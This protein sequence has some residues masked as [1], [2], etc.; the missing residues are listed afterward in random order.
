MDAGDPS[1]VVLAAGLG[2]RFGGGKSL[3][4]I[5]PGGIAI[6]DVLIR[7]AAG[8]G[9]AKMVIVVAPGM[10]ESVRTHV[11]AHRDPAA[12]VPV[13][14]VVQPLRRGRE[15][16]A[17]TADAVLATRSIIDGSFAVVN[18]DD[19]YPVDAFARLR[20]HL[21]RGPTTEHAMVAFPVEGT[22]L[23]DRPVS[24]ALVDVDD[25]RLVGI[26]E[27]TV[28]TTDAGLRFDDRSGR[29]VAIAPDRI[30]SMNMWG[31]RTS[32]FDPLARAVDEFVALDRGGEVY[33]PEVVAAMVTEGAC[34][35][36][37]VSPEACI[38]VT[39][40]EDVIALRKTLT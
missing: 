15:K 16:P 24:R 31:F 9:F 34:V 2:T 1:V 28:R 12:T 26:R 6:M 22:L 19:L 17:G 14:V 7:H 30:I 10:E 4:A 21:C 35:R 5:G 20:D 32:V 38:G 37:L 29:S 8:A 3:A 23:G 40:P 25:D 33:L 18:A 27:G 11:D 36:V 39:H 13:E